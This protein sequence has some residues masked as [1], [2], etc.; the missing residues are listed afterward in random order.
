M[1]KSILRLRK[2]LNAPQHLPQGE[3]LV[4]LDDVPHASVLVLEDP[5]ARGILK[6]PAAAPF[7]MWAYYLALCRL[8]AQDTPT[9][10]GF[11]TNSPMLQHTQAHRETRRNSAW[12]YRAIEADLQG[13]LEA[14]DTFAGCDASSAQTA[15]DSAQRFIDRLFVRMVSAAS[16]LPERDIPVLPG[17]LFDLL[18]RRKTVLACEA[19][20]AALVHAL[21]D[22]LARTGKSKDDVWAIL[23]LVIMGYD[24]L[25]GSVLY[26][27]SVGE[28]PTSYAS[29]D[30]WFKS[31]APVALLPR[32]FS[33]DVEIEGHLFVAGQLAYIFPHL[34]H[35]SQ[36]ND[37]VASS[38]SFGAGPH[39]CPGRRI[40]LLAASA[41]F[42]KIGEIPS[43]NKPTPNRHWRRDLVL[44]EK[45]GKN[46]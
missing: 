28:T 14:D 45:A 24:A 33:H 42:A 1:D 31:I 18:P 10:T 16:G 15:Y 29:Y 11:F 6:S 3:N 23:V 41:F 17:H 44:I 25:R 37:D 13:W 22:Q 35:R 36:A 26:A 27:L 20:A 12:V 9:L 2:I 34:I 5:L 19:Q 43:D 32:R 4:P 21:S 39:T 8:T 30:A 38:L 40:A 7:D 46:D